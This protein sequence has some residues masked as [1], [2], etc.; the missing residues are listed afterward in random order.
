MT[1]SNSILN[2]GI[3]AKEAS[4]LLSL[5]SE[6]KKNLALKNLKHN[7]NLNR[8]ELI[9]I[10]KIDISNAKKNNLGAT[11]IDRL[12]LSQKIIDGMISSIEEII[13]IKD[14]VGKILQEW[15]RPNGLIIQKI[16]Q[17]HFK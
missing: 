16:S 3:K 5:V 6:N 2:L 14:P 15:E 13:K 8:D 10:N 7:L 17:S 12:T 9:N 11:L 1:I 4:S